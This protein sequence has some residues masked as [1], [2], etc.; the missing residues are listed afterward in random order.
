MNVMRAAMK[1]SHE[2][3]N[4]GFTFDPSKITDVESA[5]T[6]LKNVGCE[7][8]NLGNALD[9]LAKMTKEPDCMRVLALSGAMVP[10]GMEELLCQLVERGII[11]ALVSTGANLSHSMINQIGGDNDGQAHY[12][13]SPDADD[14]DLFKHNIC[15]IYDTYVE[16]DQFADADHVLYD[17]LREEYPDT[18]YMVMKPSEFFALLGKFIKARCIFTVAAEHDVPIF[19]GA[20]SDSELGLDIMKFRDMYDFTIVLDEIGDIGKFARMIGQHEKHGTIVIGGGVPRNWTQQAFPYLENLELE[21]TGES[22]SHG[23]DYSVRFTTAVPDDGGCSGCTILE[24]IS[25]GKYNERSL[26]QTV[27]G[28]ATITFPLIVTALFQLLDKRGD[29]IEQ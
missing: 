1:P 26:H 25:W 10:A 4:N 24:N 6:A 7:G 9:V 14:I 5:I 13:G 22:N 21:T 27:Y 23:Y 20:T 15:R 3:A 29:E 12:L 11:T 17:L 8:R 2:D 19:C 18:N 16:T 28:D